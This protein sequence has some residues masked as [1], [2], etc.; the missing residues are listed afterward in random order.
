MFEELNLT[1]LEKEK[2][3]C[4]ENAINFTP[5]ILI[6]GR[7]PKEYDKQDI[8]Y[9]IEDMR[10]ERCLKNIENNKELAK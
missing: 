8:M 7:S 5:E 6:N 3:W 4:H 10:E 1:I 2:T 9:F